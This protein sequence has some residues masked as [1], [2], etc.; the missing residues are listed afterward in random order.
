MNHLPDPMASLPIVLASALMT[1]TKPGLAMDYVMMEPGEF[2]SIVM[3]LIMM[4][5]IVGMY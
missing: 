4:V 2:I 5:A 1:G 3:N